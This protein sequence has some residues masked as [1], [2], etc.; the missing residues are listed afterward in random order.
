MQHSRHEEGAKRGGASVDV[1]PSDGVD[2]QMPHAPFV[3]E[4]IPGSPELVE[5]GGVPPILVELAVREAC[6]LGENV[7][8]AM[9]EAPEHE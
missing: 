6:Q 7:E 9:E 2:V 5:R 4:D 1:M 3:H 8:G